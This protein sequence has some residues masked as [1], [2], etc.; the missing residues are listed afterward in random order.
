MKPFAITFSFVAVAFAVALL[1]LTGC[2]L[3]AGVQDAGHDASADVLSSK[4]TTSGP[5]EASVAKVQAGTVAAAVTATVDAALVK[6][7]DEVKS[8]IQDATNAIINN[9]LKGDDVKGII[10]TLLVWGLGIGFGLNQLFSFLRQLAFH[11]A[12]N[13][14][15]GD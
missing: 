8:D 13:K 10:K 12:A 2:G 9:G 7:T 14:D 15:K 6:K 4:I 11:K 5:V 1:A 3:K